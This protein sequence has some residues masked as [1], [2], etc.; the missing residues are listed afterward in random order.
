MQ[1]SATKIAVSLAGKPVVASVT[2][3]VKQAPRLL[4]VRIRT[5]DLSNSLDKDIQD[6]L[7][8]TYTHLDQWLY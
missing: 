5:R 4:F 7:F 6:R 1:E 3:N 8:L 2:G